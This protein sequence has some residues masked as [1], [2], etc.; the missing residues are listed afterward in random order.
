MQ[1]EFI[2]PSFKLNRLI[3]I[4]ELSK[5]QFMDFF[6]RKLYTEFMEKVT[7]LNCS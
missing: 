5:L 7:G 6:I 2:H 1:I 4:C 3:K